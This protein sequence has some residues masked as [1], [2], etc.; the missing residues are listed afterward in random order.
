MSNK[1]PLP[2]EQESIGEALPREMARVR[3]DVM[4]AYL[5]IG[6]AGRFALMMMRADLDRAAKVMIAGD[7]VGMLAA[8]TSLTEYNE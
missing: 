6:A 7:T 4:P 5:E 8:Y 2:T 3:D 1:A